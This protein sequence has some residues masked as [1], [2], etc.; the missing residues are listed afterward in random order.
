MHR[1]SRQL[2]GSCARDEDISELQDR[3]NNARD[4]TVSQG[5]MEGFALTLCWQDRTTQVSECCCGPGAPACEEVVAV[6]FEPV[7]LGGRHQPHAARHK[8]TSS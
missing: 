3:I 6:R 7:V 2:R 8:S 4:Q 1:L 5:L